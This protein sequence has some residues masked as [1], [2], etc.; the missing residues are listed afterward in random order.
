MNNMR[1]VVA[2]A[3]ALSLSMVGAAPAAAATVVRAD[4]QPMSPTGEI[5][6]AWG[7]V[8]F[9][10]GSVSMLC[11]AT[12]VGTVTS[13][14]SVEITAASYSGNGACSLLSGVASHVQPWTGQFDNA[15][16]LTINR[17]EVAVALLGSCGPNRVILGWNNQ[18][19]SM[20][21]NNNTFLT[22]DCTTWGTL[23]TSPRFFVQ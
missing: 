10:K 22:P 18:D 21:F 3:L 7:P 20:T 16:Q 8:A 15:T 19:S 11:T 13:A 1:M 17:M 12:V 2:T 4:G 5:F 23:S 14:G 6:T 9:Y